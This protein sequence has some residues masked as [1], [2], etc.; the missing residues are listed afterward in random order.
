MWGVA[1]SIWW[2][3]L[4]VSSINHI[5]FDCDGVLVDTEFTAAI[6]MTQALNNM[7]VDL[8]V[9]YY[10]QNFSGTTFSGIIDKYFGNAMSADE[11]SEIIDK[12]EEEV[13]KEVKLIDGVSQL[14]NILQ[15]EKSVVSNSSVRTVEHAL[16][17]TGIYDHFSGGI[18]SSEH[19]K[20]PKPA[21]DVYQYAIKTL[22][23]N[24]S[25]IIVIED[26]ISG[27]RAALAAGLRVFGFTG[28]SH[29]LPDHRQKL[30]DLGA[31]EVFGNMHELGL[32][33]GKEASK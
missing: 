13:A 3:S 10:L 19:V 6:R 15:V 20:N 14:L 28:G 11:V 24:I 21:P 32:F 27:A 8:S 23:C 1:K 26:S 22:A 30:L 17:I 25:E 18:F 12:V 33:L 5:I 16:R 29:I 2:P 31:D 9:N 7:G 4:V